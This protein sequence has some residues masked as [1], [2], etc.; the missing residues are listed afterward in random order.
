MTLR[1][2]GWAIIHSLW[3]GG[4]IALATA[5]LLTAARK[6]TPNVRYAISLLALASMV[7]LPIA[8][9]FGTRNEPIIDPIAPSAFP[10]ATDLSVTSA[11]T[12]SASQSP[13]AT[14]TPSPYP[15]PERATTTITREAVVSWLENSL[16]WLV[17]A[18]MVGLLVASA[19]LI[20]G[21]SRTRRITRNATSKASRALELR[22]EKICARLGIT[23]AIR[24]LE[25]TAI[26]VPL[27]IGAIR[28]V[29]VI[30]VSLISGLTPLQLDMLIAHELA[31][32][33]RHDYLVNL[34]QTIVETLL[35]YHPAARWIS[36]RAR[37][38]RENCCDDI[39]METCAVDPAQ[40]TSTLLL[41][42]ESR[43]EAVGLAAA[44]SGGSLLR[45]AQR[46]LT[47]RTYLELG[48]RWVAGVITI[49]AA[50]FAGNEAI[51]GIQAA[52]V[53]NKPDVALVDSVGKRGT[54]VDDSRARPGTVTKAPAGGSIADRWRW[55]ERNGGS[56]PY[57]IGYLI[58]GDP[59]SSSKFYV[60]EIPVR[61]DGNL[62]ISGRMN[63]GG[64]DLSG[65]IFSGVPLAPIVG[66][67]APNSTAMFLRV[68]NS[69]MGRRI[70]RVHIGTFSL[71]GY[72]ERRA[73]VWLDS[74]GDAESI[75]LITSLMS[76]ARDDDTRR[77]LV[78]ALGV[79]SDAN[80][81]VPRLIS[82]LQSREEEGVRREAAEW[83]GRK[84]DSRAIAALSRGARTDRSQ[85]VRQ[86]AVEAFKHM[87]S[88]SATD[89]LIAFVNS[90]ETEHLRREAI[91]SLGHRDDDRALEYLSRYVRSSSGS[92]QLRREAI[93]AL[94]NREDGRGMTV[95]A[96]IARHDGNSELRREAVE[97]LARLEPA[98]RAFEILSEI[99]RTDPDESVKSEAIETIAEVHDVRS[100]SILADIVNRNPSERLQVEAV[101]SL[102]ETVAPEKALPIVRDIA[103]KHPVARVRKKALEVMVDF[104]DDASSIEEL[105]RAVRTDPEE[106]V[107]HA[108]LEVLG[109]G[110]DRAAMKTLE[111]FINGKDPVHVREKAL[112]VYTDAA[113]EKDAT[114]ILKSVM[115][116][117]PDS[118]M[119][120]RA[121]E[122][123]NDR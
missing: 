79:H 57:W 30:P 62:T 65:V 104:H 78:A 81:V 56:D 50:L 120:S 99:V 63:F 109:D 27:V 74:A 40:Y 51:A 15:A 100:V 19:R 42:E 96:D 101:E 92:T 34:V 4:V 49:G 13:S 48:P 47:G 43:G 114:A 10:A 83:L 113:S 17:V 12:P 32:V 91:E 108:A 20:G 98:A 60:S 112:E 73:L 85:G 36:D 28:P 9:A 26:D 90:L 35:F 115:A 103:R 97:S 25:S 122:I 52:Y 118:R 117:D 88:A 93:E 89:T 82:I 107:R 58:A 11:V 31:H 38:E 46:L 87:K 22:I 77:N 68:Q 102:G 75:A 2:I 45:R 105:I 116:K 121:A 23:R 59:T 39:A 6:S 16:P 84:G 44:A 72:F 95:V 119:R 5:G 18:W 76:S 69:A 86:E 1:L 94:A 67:H 71:P 33:R 55:A 21:F 24:A 66:Q 3:L 53:P 70:D 7:A 29:V 64:G 14:P 61:L 106:D 123:L 41:L 111:S 8:T 110:K 80:V 37:E 54:I